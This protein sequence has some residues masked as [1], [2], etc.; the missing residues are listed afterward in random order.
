LRPKEVRQVLHRGSSPDHRAHRAG[1]QE[2][3]MAA[4]V[5]QV[6]RLVAVAA[7][8]GWVALTGARSGPASRGAAV[9]ATTAQPERPDRAPGAGAQH[10]PPSHP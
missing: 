1:A 3:F 4:D 10:T 8:F 9:A 5:F 2:A 7:F 6:L